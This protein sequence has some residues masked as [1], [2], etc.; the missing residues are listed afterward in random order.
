MIDD[1]RIRAITESSIA[2]LEAEP[3]SGR[4]EVSTRIRLTD[5]LSCQVTEGERTFHVD[6]PEDSGG[7]DRGPAPGTL[8]R[9]AIGACFAMDCRIWAA[10]EGVLLD[11]VEIQVTT[12]L[13]Y[14]GML[15]VADL[16]RGFET[17]SITARI[18]S[19]APREDVE[20]VLARARDLN[21][22]VWEMS[23]AVPIE[24]RLDLVPA[25][26]APAKAS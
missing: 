23:R 6:V 9:A 7:H 26:L 11:E 4:S 18:R 1:A 20:R 8:M 15:G 16:P 21:P 12:T 3:G 2:A 13:D 5:G 24:T 22:R 17:V 25:G 19:D 14:R 10:V